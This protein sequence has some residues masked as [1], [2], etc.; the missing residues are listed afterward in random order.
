VIA[1]PGRLL[2][3]VVT[4]S[5]ETVSRAIHVGSRW[6]GVPMRWPTPAVL[7]RQVEAAGF[8][9]ASQRR[10]LRLPA[11]AMLTEAVRRN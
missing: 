4:P 2:I 9:I 5:S 1:A 6:L 7:R 10:I 11:P 8:Q 3:A